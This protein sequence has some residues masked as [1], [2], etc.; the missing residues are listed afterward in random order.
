MK[1]TEQEKLDARRRLKKL[2]PRLKQ[3]KSTNECK[4]V[5]GGKGNLPAPML[6][7]RVVCA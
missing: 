6:F 3:I 4:Q 1:L 7:T 2:I 5:L